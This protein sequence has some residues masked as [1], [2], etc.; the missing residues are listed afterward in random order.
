MQPGPSPEKPSRNMQSV[1]RFPYGC[2]H[3]M[4]PPFNHVFVCF[5]V[6]ISLWEGSE[7]NIAWHAGPRECSGWGGWPVEQLEGIRWFEVAAGMPVPLPHCPLG[8][9]AFA[10][11]TA[12]WLWK[13]DMSS[14]QGAVLC[15]PDGRPFASQAE[16]G[17]G[18][19][20]L[21]KRNRGALLETLLSWTHH[22]SS[23]RLI[24]LFRLGCLQQHIISV[25]Y[26]VSW[27]TCKILCK[28]FEFLVSK[29]EETKRAFHSIDAVV[30][31]LFRF[32][33]CWSV[34]PANAVTGLYNLHCVSST[35]SVQ[36][37][38]LGKATNMRR[39]KDCI[40]DEAICYD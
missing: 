28:P 18:W 29:E 34:S 4:L 40:C 30:R 21:H 38:F 36:Y 1:R 16:L 25:N 3:Y 32:F 14:T 11:S 26:G 23:P 31:T 33:E 17:S 39:I 24:C 19:E 8:P 37:P 10:C 6:G 2:A 12:S 15:F 20:S 9:W 22:S 13:W 7:Q 35:Q 27:E 5:V